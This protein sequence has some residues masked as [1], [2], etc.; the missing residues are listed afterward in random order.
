MCQ[1]LWNLGRLSLLEI[2]G[3]VQACTRIVLPFTSKVKVKYTLIQ[4][5]RLCIGRTARRGSR[6][7]ALLFQDHG[8]RRGWGVSVTPRPLFT[9]GK[10]TVPIVQETGWAPGPVWTGAESLAHTGIRSPD[11]PARSSVAIP[12]ELPGPPKPLGSHVYFQWEIQST[13]LLCTLF[14]N[15]NKKWLKI[16]TSSDKLSQWNIQ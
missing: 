3:P 9:P 8:T 13:E 11:R 16:A 2:S 4:A 1:V 10:D 7:I 12:T 6:G 14:T 15:V 5:L